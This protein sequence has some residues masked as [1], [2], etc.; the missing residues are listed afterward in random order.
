MPFT[1]D[2]TLSLQA[3]AALVN[4]RDPDTLSTGRQRVTPCHNLCVTTNS[5]GTFTPPPQ[6]RRWPSG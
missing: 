2:T 3:L 4:T 6:T 1:H 5:P